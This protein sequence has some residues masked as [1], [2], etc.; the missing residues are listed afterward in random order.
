VTCAWI[1]ALGANFVRL[2][3]YPHHRHVVEIA[4]E[5]G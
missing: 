1:K 4:D 3:H 5:L 2:V